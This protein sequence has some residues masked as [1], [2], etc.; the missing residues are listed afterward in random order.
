MSAP[1]PDSQSDSCN[2][3][4]PYCEGSYQAEAEDYDTEQRNEECGLCG[5]IYVV[6]QE[7]EVTN[8][9]A[10]KPEATP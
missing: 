3:I 7:F 6:W 10:P 5:K 1:K 8:H 9:T 4:C 2:V